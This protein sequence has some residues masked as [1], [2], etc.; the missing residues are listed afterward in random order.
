LIN[1]QQSSGKTEN[2][3]KTIP[4]AGFLFF[5]GGVFIGKTG[6]SDHLVPEWDILGKLQNNK[7]F[8]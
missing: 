3:Q 2:P 8:T 6:G 5:D 4:F 7:A 1:H